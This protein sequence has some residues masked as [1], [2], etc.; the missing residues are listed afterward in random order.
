MYGVCG[1]CGWCL[2]LFLFLFFRFFLLGVGLVNGVVVCVG[3]DCGCGVAGD[4]R[5]CGDG[6]G[7]SGDGVISG[8]MAVSWGGSGG[9]F[10][11]WGGCG[12]G[13]GM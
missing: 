12:G 4:W 2:C 10:C 3:D 5:S 13:F 11:G 8:C 6:V 9:V 7:G 1:E